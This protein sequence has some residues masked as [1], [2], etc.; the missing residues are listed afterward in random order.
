MAVKD[1][2]WTA[3]NLVATGQEGMRTLDSCAGDGLSCPRSDGNTDLCCNFP[4]LMVTD[5]KLGS[6]H[7]TV[8]LVTCLAALYASACEVGL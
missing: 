5:W 4:L 3:T 6:L 1:C 7:P 8:L 2:D